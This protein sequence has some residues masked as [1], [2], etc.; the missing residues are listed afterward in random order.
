MENFDFAAL[1]KE[2]VV[3]TSEEQASCATNMRFF[4]GITLI[5]ACTLV[6]FGVEVLQDPSPPSLARFTV[7]AIGVYKAGKHAIQNANELAGTSL[8]LEAMSSGLS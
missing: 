7:C 4:G 6:G 1:A 8:T 5:V 3:Q 2:V